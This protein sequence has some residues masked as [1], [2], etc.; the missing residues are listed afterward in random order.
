[1]MKS[2][3]LQLKLYRQLSLFNK[4][5]YS[6]VSCD[7]EGGLREVRES[8]PVIDADTLFLG[9]EQGSAAVVPFEMK[10]R[11]SD[12]FAL[13]R[14][15][16]GASILPENLQLSLDRVLK[17]YPRR[18]LRQDVAALAESYAKMTLV[19]AE[20]LLYSNFEKS[21]LWSEADRQALVEFS[22]PAVD[23]N[24]KETF[25]FIASQLPFMFAPLERV[26]S[27]LARRIPS[28]APV[29]MLDF[30]T[31]PGTAIFAAQKHGHWVDSLS[32]IMAIDVSEAMLEMSENLIRDNES[33]AAKV[34]WRR[35][36]AM[37]PN[38]PKYNLV[39]AATVLSE[40]S[41]DHLRNQS[42]D[43]LWQQC[44]DVLVL[45]DRGNAEGF[46]I[47]RNARD[48]LI[49]ASKSNSE[50]L[51]IVAP[52]RLQ[53]ILFHHLLIVFCSVLMS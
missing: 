14:N 39:V 42:I 17:G 51:H 20:S 23:Y 28:F 32:K 31:G 19:S 30:G 6:G 26:F 46:R 33:L 37:S 47:L 15:D 35:Y 2:S 21:S 29:S 44:D 34:E 38:R 45:I 3:S 11:L 16:L 50:P 5:L 25:A 48:R 1:M 52:V 49:E 4:R 27:E 40:L 10:K 18:Q 43:H 13:G 22:A 41:D 53:I 12:Q 24:S 36:M 9:S 8:Q 7:S